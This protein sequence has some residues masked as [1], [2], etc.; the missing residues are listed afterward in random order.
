MS[1]AAVLEG[2]S[3]TTDLVFTVTLS[4]A[5]TAQ[6]TVDYATADGTAAAGS[7]YVATSGALTF[8]AGVTSQTLA[9]QIIG[10]LPDEADETL[11]V[12]LTNAVGAE[13]VIADA[14]GVGT[15]LDDDPL[16]TLSINS[17][18]ARE[19]DVRTTPFVFTVT[20]AGLTERAVRVEYV[21]AGGT[22]RSPGDYRAVRGSLIFAPGQTSKTITV[23]VV[24][25]RIREATEVFYVRLWNAPNA[26]IVPGTSRGV[27]INDD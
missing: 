12:N 19:G 22:A 21:T 9:V 11:S 24:G 8:D 3:G 27:I 13:A 25:D 1:D 26:S 18:A 20:L 17:V 7:D 10:D 2:D 4:P 16:P 5:A 6:V 15:I 14:Q 23:P